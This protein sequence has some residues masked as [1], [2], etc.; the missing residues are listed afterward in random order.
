MSFDL[1]V[2]A[3]DL[4]L[5]NGDLVTIT[6]KNKLIQDVLK[7]CLTEVGALPYAPWYGSFISKSLIGS[8]LDT[9]II[10]N[11]AKNQLQNSLEN[12]QKLQE[13]QVNNV[14]QKVTPDELIAGIG[15]INIER[16][17][18]D[19]RLFTVDVSIVNKTFSKASA[20]FTVN[21]F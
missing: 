19:P 7:I 11:V 16:N 14:N 1:Q 21:N 13:L 12:L 15:A 18:V 10:L 17:Q 4:V 20:S 2:I 6:G 3:G 9:D 5:Q 8:S